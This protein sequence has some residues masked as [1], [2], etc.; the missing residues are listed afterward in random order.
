MKIVVIGESEPGDGRPSVS[1]LI[2]CARLK[3]YPGTPHGINHTQEAAQ[4][5]PARAPEPHERKGS[6]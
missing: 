1:G 3:V 5:E 2:D 6:Q 4:P